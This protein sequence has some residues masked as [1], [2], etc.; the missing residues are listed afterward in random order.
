MNK[1]KVA[2][3]TGANRGLGLEVCRQ[4]AQKEDI[5]VILS[6]RLE[7]KGQEVVDKLKE[8]GLD[9]QF[10]QCDVNDAKSI[11]NFAQNIKK[12]FAEDN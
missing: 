12:D 10:Y 11:H 3:V 1:G 7:A 6:S 8:E 2:V 9:I 5:Q 4:L